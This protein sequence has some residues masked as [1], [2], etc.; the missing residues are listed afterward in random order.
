[1][2]ITDI[3]DNF[4]EMRE[5]FDEHV[6][7]QAFFLPTWCTPRL[8]SF[9]KQHEAVN[10]LRATTDLDLVAW[11][12]KVDGQLNEIKKES[13]AL[14]KPVADVVHKYYAEDLKLWE[15]VRGG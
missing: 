7:S 3:L 15:Q 10:M 4:E 6:E 2:T 14:T 5:H 12:D 8:I 1:M 9:E 13:M 11:A